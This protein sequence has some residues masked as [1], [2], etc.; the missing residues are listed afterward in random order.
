MSDGFDKLRACLM[1]PPVLAYA[2]YQLLFII[3]TDGSRQDL[4]AGLSQYQDGVEHSLCESG[5]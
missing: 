3:T 5:S 4:G 1:V 2:N